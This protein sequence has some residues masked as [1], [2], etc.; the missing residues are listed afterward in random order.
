MYVFM[1]QLKYRSVLVDKIRR[2]R[3]HLTRMHF[4]RSRTLPEYPISRY[5]LGENSKMK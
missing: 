3:F 2:Q 1:L 4:Q 5:L